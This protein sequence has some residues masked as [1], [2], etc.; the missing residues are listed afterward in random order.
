MIT[1]SFFL[2]SKFWVIV[3]FA[4]IILILAL[5]IAGYPSIYS[6]GDSVSGKAVMY[7]LLVLFSGFYAAGVTM[8]FDIGAMSSGWKTLTKTYTEYKTD[9]EEKNIKDG[10]TE[11][12]YLPMKVEQFRV[13]AF[14]PPKHVYVGLKHVRTGQV[15]ENQYVSKHCSN[16]P[17]LHETIN[18]QVTPFHYDGRPNDVRWEFNNLSKEI[19][20]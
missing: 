20:S 19:C 3:G 6:G 12:I 10:S 1:L 18:I 7:V 11:K 14:D 5:L 4:L 2:L 15:Y 9:K 13:V 16:S 17:T 8:L